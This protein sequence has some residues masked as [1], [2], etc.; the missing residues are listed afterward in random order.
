VEPFKY[1]PTNVRSTFIISHQDIST[2]TREKLLQFLPKLD[3]DR[4][5]NYYKIPGDDTTMFTSH[6]DTA[7]RKQLVTNLVST[8]DSDG[9]EHILTDG[10]SILGADD[11][12]AGVA[13]MLYMMHNKVPGLYYFFLGEEVGGI[14]LLSGDYSKTSYLENIK[15]AFLDRREDGISY[16]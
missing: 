10:N 15:G 5:G 2:W 1:D 8:V 12:K 16:N 9:D 4:F 11:N 13:V 6:L 7:D 3:K 14:G